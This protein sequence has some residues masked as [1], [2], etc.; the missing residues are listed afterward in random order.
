LL[1]QLGG[2]LLMGYIF[3]G[4]CCAWYMGLRQRLFVQSTVWLLARGYSASQYGLP[5]CSFWQGACS[6]IP[7]GRFFEVVL[8][9]ELAYNQNYLAHPAS[10]DA[11]RYRAKIKLR[12]GKKIHS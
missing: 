3:I 2:K 5:M 4:G 11:W 1:I 6:R 10:S 12:A 7:T 9:V 8:P